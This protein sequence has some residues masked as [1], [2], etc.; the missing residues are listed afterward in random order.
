MAYG[1]WDILPP[2]S[3]DVILS[4]QWLG[5]QSFTQK[6]GQYAMIRI[7]RSKSSTAGFLTQQASPGHAFESGFSSARLWTQESHHQAFCNPWW[8]RVLRTFSRFS[9]TASIL[10]LFLKVFQERMLI[11]LVVHIL[12]QLCKLFR[13]EPRCNHCLFWALTAQLNIRMERWNILRALMK[14]GACTVIVSDV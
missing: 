4:P 9:S 8:T 10:W 1:V 2:I 3:A 12:K 6:R 11:D 7:G 13:R 14:Q 5:L